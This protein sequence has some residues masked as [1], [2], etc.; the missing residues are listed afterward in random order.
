M[1]LW[2]P[3]SHVEGLRQW[4]GRILHLPGTWGAT[5]PLDSFLAKCGYFLHP[6][7]D[8]AFIFRAQYS[9]CFVQKEKANYR[10]E[11]RIF[12]KGVTRLDRS[13][14]YIMKCPVLRSRLGQEHVHCG[15]TFIQV[16]RPLPLGSD[17]GQTP[18]L[19][20]LRGEL[21]ASLEDASLIGLY[22]DINS[23]TVTV[24]SP[25][26]ELLQTQE[27]LNA[28]VELL[29]LWLVS[30]PYAYSLEAACPPVSSQPESEVFVHVPKQRLGLV[31][32]GSRIEDTL[33]LKFLRVHQSN[34]FTVTESRDLVVVSIPAA[35]VLQAQ[36]CQEARGAPGTQAFY[37]V[38]L[39]LEFTEMAAPVL[40]TVENVF[41][42]VGSGTESSA[43]TATPKTTPSHPSSG[44]ETPPAGTPSAASPQFQAVG[45]AAQERLSWGLVR[46]PSDELAKKGLGPSLPTAKPVGRSWMSAAS[47]VPRAMQDWHSPQVPPGKVG[48]PGHPLPSATISSGSTGGIH[49]GPRPPRPV[50]PAP[51]APT[52]HLS[53]DVSSPLLPSWRSV[54][55]QVLPVSGPSVTLTEGL[56]TGR[57]E[58]D[59]TQPPGSP[60]LPRGWSGGDGAPAEPIEGET[61]EVHEKFQPW[62]RPSRPSLT[63]G[64]LVSHH[65]PIEPQD[66]SST[67][68]VEGI[69][70][71]EPGLSGEARRHLGLSSSEPSQDTKGLGLPALLG[72]DATS[73]IPRVKQPDPSAS[74][75][76]SGPKPPERPGVG[77]AVPL[78]ALTVESLTAGSSGLT[79]NPNPESST[80]G[81]SN[82]AETWSSLSQWVGQEEA[83]ARTPR[84]PSAQTPSLWALAET[85]SP[86]QAKV[87]HPLPAGQGA[88]SKE[89]LTEP[90]LATSF[91]SHRPPEL[92]EH[93]RGAF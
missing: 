74:A 36:R 59:P 16:S 15:P 51:P 30:G 50:F 62:T 77:L 33:S 10:L 39:S 65:S 27:V 56:G 91:E 6:A 57:A 71:S 93:H 4:L 76:T 64:A 85:L 70:R 47:S 26:Q 40:W 46:W 12:Q 14:R 92:S 43:S 58:Q 44:T 53:S 32:R 89:E 24:Q 13:D 78:A 22:V 83:G 52:M 21:V 23:T 19:L 17:S 2:V 28:S 20:S 42:C 63:E 8:G 25:R 54:Q 37:R 1:T 67:M 66:T 69:P 88:L 9:A 86:S 5:D 72:R 60:L 11:I 87:R 48:L 90:T 75:G 34:T 35:G 7:L 79:G 31:K 29:T 82:G 68:E 45:P 84:P 81:E 80:V 3:R 18:W 73:T 41:Q 38:D 55:S 49:A 61:D